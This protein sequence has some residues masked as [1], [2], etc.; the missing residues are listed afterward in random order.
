MA[1]LTA[2]DV[3]VLI[4]VALAALAG[5]ARGFVGEIVSLLAW[6]AGIVAVRLLYTPAKAIAAH[7][8]GTAAGGAVLALVVLFLAAFIAVRIIGGALSRGTKASLIGPIDRV[9]GFGFGAAKGV[10][11]AALLFLL[12]NLT[13][14]TIDPGEPTPAWIT[15]SRTAPTLAMVS[16]AL[17]DFVEERRRVAPDTAQAF[18][19]VREPGKGNPHIPGVRDN[20]YDQGQRSALDRLLDKQEKAAPG[21]PI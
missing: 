11:G 19:G 6:G 5:M 20:G 16:K 14:D 21:T 2:F 17:V 8:T 18:P 15:R 1:A 9:L 3:V 12:V 13:F 7:L 10:L 4:I